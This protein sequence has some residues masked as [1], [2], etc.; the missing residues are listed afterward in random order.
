M[1]AN[2]KLKCVVKGIIPIPFECWQAWVMIYLSGVSL[3]SPLGFLFSQSLPVSSLTL[4]L[5][6]PQRVSSTSS[7]V[8]ELAKGTLHSCI[9]TSDKSIK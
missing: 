5:L 4:S 8:S 9:Q 3:R 6:S 2:Q 1:R 7:I